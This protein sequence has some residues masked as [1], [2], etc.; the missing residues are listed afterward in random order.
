MKKALRF[1][2]ISVFLSAVIGLIYPVRYWLSSLLIDTAYVPVLKTVAT[3]NELHRLKEEVNDLMIENLR[4]RAVINRELRQ[5]IVNSWL[6]TPPLSDSTK[7][8][9]A[10][11]IAYIPQGIPLKIVLDKGSIDGVRRNCV[12]LAHNGL[13]GRIVNV[14]PRTS[15]VM[16][17][18]DHEF[19]VGVVDVRSG[20]LG[21]VSGS[22]MRL[23][24]IPRGVD[25]RVGDTLI[26]SGLSR[27][28]PYGLKVAEIT[29]ID[30]SDTQNMFARIKISPFYNYAETAAFWVIKK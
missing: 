11:G 23:N 20:V 17:I 4:L 27:I 18:Y 13:A 21:V 14:R 29:S 1:Y 24:Y 26:T 19:K 8:M 28:Y 5:R 6:K 10:I 22:D 30:T 2:L 15:T 12:V 25:V 3:V 9:P 7:L 16:S